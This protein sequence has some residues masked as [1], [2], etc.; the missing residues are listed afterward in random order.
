MKLK[1]ALFQQVKKLGLLSLLF[2]FTCKM[3]FT[4]SIVILA[5][6]VEVGL[7]KKAH[8]Y[9]FKCRPINRHIVLILK[10]MSFHVLTLPSSQKISTINSF[11]LKFAITKI[12]VS[13]K[14][15][16]GILQTH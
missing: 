16:N 9:S 12:L 1:I 13:Y 7:Y 2:H 14:F 6:K 4:S 11:S 8:I 5:T 15:P 3:C 10:I